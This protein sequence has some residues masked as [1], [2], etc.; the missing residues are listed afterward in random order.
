MI[1]YEFIRL[2]HSETETLF[3]IPKR[4]EGSIMK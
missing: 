4:S 2:C 3:V 1:N